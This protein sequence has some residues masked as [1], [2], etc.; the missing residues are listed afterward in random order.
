MKA[1]SFDPDDGIL[2]ELTNFNV[3][4]NRTTF[5]REG[6]EVVFSA[7]D[8]I[9]ELATSIP[10][11]NPLAFPVYSDFVFFPE[12][13]LRSLPPGCNGKHASQAFERRSKM[14]NDG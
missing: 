8:A 14:F 5:P 10:Q 9:L 7:L 11:D 12:L 6:I 1:S 3:K 13:V 4:I 2:H